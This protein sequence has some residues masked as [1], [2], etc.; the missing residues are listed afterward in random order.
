MCYWCPG[1][2]EM[3]KPGIEYLT[4]AH[5]PVI[6]QKRLELLKRAEE[7]YMNIRGK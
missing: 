1:K 5:D 3:R 4:F 6:Q 7:L 2:A